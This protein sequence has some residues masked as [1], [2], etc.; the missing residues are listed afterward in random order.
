MVLIIL[1]EDGIDLLIHG[2]LVVFSSNAKGILLRHLVLILELFCLFFLGLLVNDVNTIVIT[3]HEE[4]E[5]LDLAPIEFVTLVCVQLI[6]LPWGVDEERE[7]GPLRV[8]TSCLCSKLVVE[9]FLLGIPILVFQLTLVDLVED[10]GD[11]FHALKMFLNHL[12]EYLPHI[13]LGQL[14]W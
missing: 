13:N 5:F 10:F 14:F 2:V 4:E 7:S 8:R 6:E 11:R 1:F 12:V 9:R 3:M